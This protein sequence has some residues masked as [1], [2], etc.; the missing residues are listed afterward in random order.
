VLPNTTS[1]TTKPTTTVST[2]SSTKTTTTTTTTYTTSL[3]T[4]APPANPITDFTI[5]STYCSF[6]NQ[7]IVCNSS[8][9]YR[10]YDGT[11]NN[12]KYPILGAAN[13]PYSRFLPP[14]YQVNKYKFSYLV[15]KG[16]I[17]DSR[18]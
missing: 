2:I 6:Q 9:I 18:I 1:S 5:N 15:C 10:S 11:C 14:A 13:T 3:T 16:L 17:L 7:F 12:L 8:Y 4:S